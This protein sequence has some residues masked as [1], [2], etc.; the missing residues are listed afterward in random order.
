VYVGDDGPG[1]LTVTN[2]GTVSVE[3][4]NGVQI[5]TQGKVT[6][7]G[8]LDAW[9][10]NGGVVAP[11]T[12]VGTLTI[13]NSPYR[14]YATGALQIE[15]ASASSYDKLNFPDGGA[16]LEGGTL[17]VTLLGGYSPAAGTAFDLMNWSPFG[18]ITGTFSTLDL[19]DLPGTLDWDTSQLYSAG[20][21]RVIGNSGLAGDYNNNGVVDAADYVVW[22]NNLDTNN[23][24]PNDPTGGTIGTTQ[25]NTWRSH[26]GQAAG[27]GT[28]LANVPEPT[29]PL[30]WI[31]AI[32]SLVGSRFAASQPRR[33]SA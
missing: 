23:T 1:T 31:A 13:T 9:V 16:F 14:Q 3:S 2:G 26:F 4:F 19:P 25:Y 17:D 32:V 5:L 18:S 10:Y 24:L 21:L 30:I 6:G 15:L 20:I 12:S 8:T 7:N 11:G 22:R 27:N 29:S 28:D 33:D